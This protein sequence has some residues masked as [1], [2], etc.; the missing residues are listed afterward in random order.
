MPGTSPGMTIE[1][2]EILE[3]HSMSGD[4][5]LY[6][7]DGKVGTVTLNRPQKLNAMTMEMRLAIEQQL[8][9]ADADES[10][11]V[12]VLRGAGRSFC[13]GFDVGGGNHPRPWRH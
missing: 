7:T 11:S 10:T 9:R 4:I 6:A 2:V 5:V 12:I 3:G 8:R 1:S 13:V